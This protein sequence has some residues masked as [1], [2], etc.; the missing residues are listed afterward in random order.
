MCAPPLAAREPTELGGREPC[1]VDFQTEARQV[2]ISICDIPCRVAYEPQMP[3][4]LEIKTHFSSMGRCVD[5]E[6]RRALDRKCV[7]RS[8]RAG[9]RSPGLS[10]DTAP[11]EGAALHPPPF[12]PRRLQQWE[13]PLSDPHGGGWTEGTLRTAMAPSELRWPRGCKRG[14]DRAAVLSQVTK[15]GKPC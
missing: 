5:H 2:P 3:V 12:W 10:K 9:C 6:N 1:T 13:G 4:V 14:K 7:S 11:A 15:R 8:L